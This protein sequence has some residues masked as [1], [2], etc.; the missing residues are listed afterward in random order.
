[1]SYHKNTRKEDFINV[2]KAIGEQATLNLSKNNLKKSAA[3]KDD[4]NFVMNLLNLP[5]EDRQTKSEQQL[6]VINSQLEVEKIKLKQ[7]ERKIELQKALAKGQATQQSS[8]GDTNN[9]ENLIKS[10]KTMESENK[11]QHTDYTVN[12]IETS[13]SNQNNLLF[14]ELQYVD[15]IVDDNPLSVTLDSDANSVIINSKY[16]S[17]EK[18][19]ILKSC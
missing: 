1:M 4:P 19:F 14:N 12:Q 8:K 6:Q 16:V 15:V 11:N 9:L 18:E 5:I 13:I 3:F 2:L 17:E 7:I 10:V